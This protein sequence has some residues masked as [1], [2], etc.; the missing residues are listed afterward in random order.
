VLS[1]LLWLLLLFAF[2]AAEARLVQRYQR[3]D[4]GA[5]D[6]LYTRYRRP[7][8]TF[9]ARLMGDRAEAEDAFVETWAHVAR[10]LPTY[11]EQGKFRSFLYTVARREAYHLLQRRANRDSRAALARDSDEASIDRAAPGEDPEAEAS[12]RQVADRVEGALGA[13]SEELRACFLL[14]HAEGLTVPEVAEATGLSP[15]TVKRR[16]G[17]ARQ[18]LAARLRDLD[19]AVVAG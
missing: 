15:A 10:A 14:Y 6:E 8:L 16:I 7:L 12:R 13:L 5:L 3:G 9:L 17:A 2:A 1:N 4:A 19:P 18:V 11:E